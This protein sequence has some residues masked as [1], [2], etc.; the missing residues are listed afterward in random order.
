MKAGYVCLEGS[1]LRFSYF[2]YFLGILVMPKVYISQFVPP[3]I[4]SICFI[5]P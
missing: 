3:K 1:S 2:F 4:S 5:F